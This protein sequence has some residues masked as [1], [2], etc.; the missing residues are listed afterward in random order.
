MSR[1]EP[2]TDQQLPPA[3]QEMLESAQSMMGF[4]PNDGRIMARDPVLLQAFGTLV[5][6]MLV[7]AMRNSFDLAAELG[8]PL[9]S[10]A[11]DHLAAVLV[12][13]ERRESTSPNTLAGIAAE[14]CNTVESLA[15][16]E[17]FARV[18]ARAPESVISA[19]L[20]EILNN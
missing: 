1:L 3:A 7:A 17:V 16:S 9:G 10:E 18:G 4:T 8:E 6:A 2:L 11:A 12:E 5:R 15:L 20:L 19:A 14:L 13:A